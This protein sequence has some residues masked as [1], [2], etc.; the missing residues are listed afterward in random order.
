[1]Y[2]IIVIKI[3]KIQ[4]YIYQSMDDKKFSWQNDS[5]SLQT[6]ISASNSISDNILE[7]I[8]NKF[9]R[10]IEK[11][12]LWISGKVIFSVFDSINIE[13][14]LNELFE[15][16]YI[17]FMGVI[18]LNYT[19]FTLENENS[20][21]ID[22]KNIIDKAYE[23]LDES[24]QNNEIIFTHRKLLFKFTEGKEEN[25]EK[26]KNEDDYDIFA[27][28]LR[29]LGEFGN[30]I[31]KIE[32]SD[33]AEQNKS[34]KIAVVKA[35]INNMQQIFQASKNYTDFNTLSEILKEH[36]SLKSLKDSIKS[37]TK[38]ELKG[39]ILPF[40]AVGD[41]IF[42]V[43]RI[44]SVLHSIVILGKL[45]G[46]INEKIKEAIPD[47]PLELTISVG[48]TFTDNHM[49]IRYYREV[50][51]KELSLAKK[52]TKELKASQISLGAS[53]CGNYFSLYKK[54]MGRGES[55]GLKKFMKEIDELKFLKSK[56]I[57][58]N[59]FLNQIVISHNK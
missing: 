25:K 58:S 40:Y 15:E 22:D 21:N 53:I 30:D 32:Y 43:T 35:D 18:T 1:M 6:I 28:N 59:T 48:V 42:F 8:E 9:K 37:Y 13:N 38:F 27:K 33:N 51:E 7:K 23:K 36:V 29:N 45:I 44:D 5:K 31:T 16:I 52:Y 24:K 26:T 46:K 50:V 39:K 4:K 12:Y 41:D 17:E 14:K 57:F 19:F 56:E 20:E 34:R 55:D 11:K 3:D 47:N 49:P 10:D 2:K 54:S